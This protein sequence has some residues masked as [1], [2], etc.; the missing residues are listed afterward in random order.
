MQPREILHGDSEENQKTLLPSYSLALNEI[1]KTKSSDGLGFRKNKDFNNALITKLVAIIISCQS[2]YK[3]IGG[4]VT[5]SN[6]T[7]GGFVTTS[8]ISGYNHQLS[9]NTSQNC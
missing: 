2:T 4:F 5:T 9:I 1:C 7:I 3:T 6:I 8:K